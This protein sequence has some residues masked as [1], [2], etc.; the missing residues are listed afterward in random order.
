MEPQGCSGRWA[1]IRSALR[2]GLRSYGRILDFVRPYWLYLSVAAASLVLISLL[3]LAMPWAVKNMV[4]VI[5][6]D[7]DLARL[8]RI[9]LALAG[10]FVLRAVLGR[11]ARGGQPAPCDLRAPPVPVPGLFRRAAR[12]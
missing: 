8:N 9:A 4:D 12:W 7:Q 3:S 5:S 6:T 2:E 1:Q 10:I 11:R